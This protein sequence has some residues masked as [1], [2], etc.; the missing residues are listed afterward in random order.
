MN[1]FV[2][3]YDLTNPE[4]G[5][6]YKE[7]NLER[8]HGIPV[9]TLV[10]LEWNQWHGEGA[11][12]HI[13]ARLWVTSH[14]RDCDGTPLY[15]V[16][17]HRFSLKEGGFHGFTEESLTP[18]PINQAIH[19]GC[20]LPDWF[21]DDEVHGDAA[22]GWISVDDRLPKPHTEV[23]AYGMDDV[24]PASYVAEDGP[25]TLRGWYSGGYRIEDE[26]LV[27]HWQPLFKPLPPTTARVVGKAVGRAVLMEGGE[28]IEDTGEVEMPLLD[29]GVDSWEELPDPPAQ[30]GQEGGQA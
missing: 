6:T 27:T 4:T 5:K 23:W 28:V 8:E 10:E 30:E 2:L 21:H 11:C 25:M 7:K 1:P 19:D 13:K 15:S 26:G 18:I 29:S 9:G 22:T 17:R 16:G 20:E 12:W 14:D 24:F 3:I